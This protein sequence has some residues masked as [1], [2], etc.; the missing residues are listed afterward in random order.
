MLRRWFWYIFAAAWLG[1]IWIAASLGQTSS[2][3]TITSL[4]SSP[5]TSNIPTLGNAITSGTDPTDVNGFRLY[6]NGTFN[7][8]NTHTV[9]WQNTST[10]VST[11]FTLE[12]GIQSVLPSQIVVAIP[13]ALFS[14]PVSSPVT[15]NVTV[16]EQ[17]EAN[18]APPPVVSNSSLFSIN[19]PMAST[20]PV[21]PNGMVGVA[22]SQNLLTGGTPP[23]TASLSAGAL[24]PG[25]SLPQ[26]PP[27][28]TATAKL[29][30]QAVIDITAGVGTAATVTATL[31]TPA[32]ATANPGAPATITATQGTTPAV[33]ANPCATATG[34]P[35]YAPIP[36]SELPSES[37]YTYYVNNVFVT[38]GGS[39]YPAL[40]SNI[41]VV[42]GN[43]AY[44]PF[45]SNCINPDS[46]QASAPTG[47][48]T[49][50]AQGQ[51]VSVTVPPYSVINGPA[52]VYN[53]PT[54]NL[55]PVTFPPPPA[56]VRLSFTAGTGVYDT[57]PGAVTFTGGGCT[58]EPTATVQASSG[59]PYTVINLTLLIPGAGCTAPPTYRFPVPGI[60]Y[61]IAPGNAGSAYGVVPAIGNG[62]SLGIPTVAGCT[63][64]VFTVSN[65]AANGGLS[66][67]GQTQVGSGCTLAQ[68]A[69]EAPGI[70]SVNVTSGG[71]AYQTAPAASLPNGTCATNPSFLVAA[72]AAGSLALGTSTITVSGYGVGC[73]AAAVP[74]T[75]GAPG[76]ASV[77]VNTPGSGYNPSAPP[78][79]SS[80]PPITV[81]GCS[82]APQLVSTVNSSGNV[83]A[84]NIFGS[85]FGS[86]NSPTTI[87]MPS[88]TTGNL[89]SPTV[90]TPG[91]G[92]SN[93]PPPPITLPASVTCSIAP[94]L[95]ANVDSNGNLTGV[96][97][98]GGS[99]CSG[100]GQLIIPPPGFMGASITN[101]G[102]GY[103]ASAP[104]L[105]TGSGCTVEPVGTATVTGG[106]VTGITFIGGSNTFGYGCTSGSTI[107]IASPGL[108]AVPLQGTPTLA[109]TF[110]FT[111]L[112]GDAWGNSN[113][114]PYT[115]QVV[116]IPR[117][118]I[119]TTS[120]PAG[121]AGAPY[122]FTLMA[123]G[124]LPFPAP[125]PP[126]KW[127]ATG[128]PNSL[129]L[130]NAGVIN[131]TWTTAGN[132]NVV[133]TVNDNSGQTASQTYGVAVSNPIVPLQITTPSPLPQAT[134]GVPYGVSFSA[135][136]GAG[137]PY[138]FSNNTQSGSPPPGLVYASG[139]L[140]GTPTTPG[141]F[142]FSI[143]VADSASGTASK[144]FSLVVAP[145]A[146]TITTASLPNGQVGVA[147]GGQ[148]N[149]TGGVPIVSAAGVPSYT[150]QIGGLP[151]GLTASSS[152]GAISGTPTAPGSSS[153]SVTVIDSAGTTASKSFTITI[154]APPL[155]ITGSLPN[156]QVGV[157]YSGQ[158]VGAGGVP[159]LTLQISGLPAGLTPSSS[160]AISG[161]PTAAGSSSVTVTVTDSATPTANKLTK[162]FSV[163]I[164]PAAITVTTTSLPN[165]VVG[166]AYLA[167]L[168]ASGGVPSG[169]VPGY[170]FAAIGLPSG[171]SVSGASITGT[172]TAS[173]NFTVGVTATDSTGTTSPPANLAL[174]IAPA[175]LTITPTSLSGVVGTA[176]SATLAV[177]G[178]GI[179]PYTW[180]VAANSALPPGLSLSSSAGVIS[181]TP[182]APTAPGSSV[183]VTV[184]DSAVPPDTATGTLSL[185]IALP[186]APPL[187][188]TGLSASSSSLSQSTLQV[189]LG[190]AY[191]VAVTVNLTLTFTPSP[192][193]GAD[194]PAVGFSVGSCTPLVQDAPVPSGCPL[195]TTTITV[196]AGQTAGATSVG[197]QT[198]SVAGVI[199]IT[200]QLVAA[201]QN[202]TPAPAPSQTI[203]IPAAA[204][205]ITSV[206]AAST[207]TGFTVTVVGFSNTRD[208]SQA[209]FVFTAA[210]GANLQT[211]QLTV[212][213]SS[214]FS[215]WYQSAA[216]V[217]FGS[218]FTLTQPFTVTGNQQAVAS[219]AVTL[220]NS[221][222]TSASKTA[223]V[224]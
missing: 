35:T 217:P 190:S 34:T 87:T 56:S 108:P 138:T 97:V 103:S 39:C 116:A 20:G 45:P 50:N 68:P 171:L 44:P 169:G 144:A 223:T 208:L 154:T 77:T 129:T 135:S 58:T 146:L 54:L 150:W 213:L 179:T 133:I 148:L 43:N 202:I 65:G 13:S 24:P 15:V 91:T 47:L 33:V 181:G 46:A 94:T 119:L 21:L 109:G 203:Q 126:Y 74:V 162:S 145:A 172:P 222:G 220:T 206:T 115:L 215:A 22:Y 163:T 221:V 104:P 198:G 209:V 9:T 110:G 11:S 63:L 36:P 90:I 73:P 31:G 111:V 174:T 61:S 25:L 167:S 189:S 207:S 182:T 99:A 95:T 175:V 125:L 216:S 27:L 92:Y 23:Y 112:I 52:C 80:T 57:L 205:V 165:G 192:A 53:D 6:I 170:T 186:P 7:T 199:T 137:G 10:N 122:T 89:Q 41:P 194:D 201:G 28:A 212:S 152:T 55:N 17:I 8:N 164:A 193:S 70:L 195:R 156:G 1:A 83:T 37:A 93:N 200:A 32:A 121:Q 127:S 114:F 160:G 124:G 132:F 161:T 180:A 48:A 5:L 151:A 158:V 60:T 59:P 19:P 4:Q 107:T 123:T 187:T 128:L 173:G 197:V 42:F 76:I 120:L 66:I 134:V 78:S 211:G 12:N 191:P 100:T 3:L 79:T 62:I 157:P 168:A 64:P 183:S 224:P 71:S 219:V 117:L 18:N 38:N 155:T 196:P 98:A 113:P 88:P 130:S 178:S 49:T 139:A 159:P 51:I 149:A 136:G 142:S 101:G 131:G 85:D 26:P 86:C 2:P 177:T 214:V 72:P 84:V 30:T 188:Y 96:T 176:F 81:S 105:V 184:T 185:T 75:I 166:T 153:V 210:S 69:V 143:S 118:T 40:V 102:S 14:T 29:G 218:Q 204:P 67:A 106:A 82:I 141:Q 140:G 16:T 147:Y